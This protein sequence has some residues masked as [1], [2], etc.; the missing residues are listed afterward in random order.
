MSSSK[1]SSSDPNEKPSKSPP[2]VLTEK[3]KLKKL[4]ADKSKHEKS[5][6]YLWDKTHNKEIIV[7]EHNEEKKELGKASRVDT[8]RNFNQFVAQVKMSVDTNLPEKPFFLKHQTL[9]DLIKKVLKKNSYLYPRRAT[10]NKDGEVEEAKTSINISSSAVAILGIF[11]EMFLIHGIGSIL[12]N[13]IFRHTPGH[14]ITPTRILSA[15]DVL[16]K[17]RQ[18][19]APVDLNGCSRIFSSLFLEKH[20]DRSN[21]RLASKGYTLGNPIIEMKTKNEEYLNRGDTLTIVRLFGNI[22]EG[23][24]QMDLIL[25]VPKYKGDCEVIQSIGQILKD[26]KTEKREK[27]DALA[28]A[29]APCMDRLKKIH[30]ERKVKREKATADKKAAAAAAA[31]DP[32]ASKRSKNASK[33]KAGGENDMVDDE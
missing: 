32:P 16:V 7:D 10:K 13:V 23:K 9:H 5:Y 29:L 8:Y 14:N 18:M 19:L 11:L 25:N 6:R 22:Q 26:Q 12:E 4:R 27:K 30:A 17:P 2:K 3:E 21:V 15:L 28:A 24:N 20:L 1:P 31:S 33:S